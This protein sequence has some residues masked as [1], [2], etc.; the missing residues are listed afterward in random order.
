MIE[1]LQLKPTEE[2][3]AQEHE[4]DYECS[5]S[6]KKQNNAQILQ[7]VVRVIAAVLEG[8]TSSANCLVCKLGYELFY[9]LFRYQT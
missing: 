6:N 9:V 5:Q 8:L 2:P 4:T 7:D 3:F 1:S